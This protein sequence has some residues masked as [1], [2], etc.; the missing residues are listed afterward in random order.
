MRNQPWEYTADDY[1]DVDRE[2]ADFADVSWR[3]CNLPLWNLAFML[4]FLLISAGLAGLWPRAAAFLSTSG[5]WMLFIY[6]G[7]SYLLSP[8][9]QWENLRWAWNVWVPLLVL[10]LMTL[11]AMRLTRLFPRGMALLQARRWS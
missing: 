5:R 10:P 9:Y 7:H 11:A 1:G 4:Q 6:A 2:Y 8:L 3:H